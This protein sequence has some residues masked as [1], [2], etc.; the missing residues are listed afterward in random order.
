[1]GGA[2][3]P[4]CWLYGLRQ[5]STGGYRLFGGAIWQ[6]PGGLTPMSTSQNFCCQ[7]PC[8]C[9]EAQPP[10]ASAGDPLTVAGM[11]SSVSYG[12]TP[13][14]FWVLMCTLLCVCP[15]R[16]ETPVSPS[17]VKVM[18]SNPASLQS[19]IHWEFLL[20]LPDPQV[21]KPNVGLTTFTP[22]GGLLWYNCS[23]VCESPP[24]GYGI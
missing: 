17:L 4:P 16:V 11:S 20:P 19:L 13:T 24:S 23:P 22:V 12:V 18:Q 1:M 21:G 15:P 9:G 5:L 8:P 2:E 3:F 10:P 14:S 7:C 6:T